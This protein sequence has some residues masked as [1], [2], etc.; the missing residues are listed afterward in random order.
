MKTK[1]AFAVPALATP[2][3]RTAWAVPQH[4]QV[5]VLPLAAAD[6]EQQLYL[7]RR[8]Q[9]WAWQAQ[10]QALQQLVFFNEVQRS[11]WQGFAPPAS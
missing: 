8:R 5:A 7:L 10:L 1:T 9:Q 4:A 6:Y 3:L 2:G 11:T